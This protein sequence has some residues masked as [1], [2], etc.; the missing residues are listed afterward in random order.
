[1]K[2]NLHHLLTQ[3]IRS[4]SA[5]RAAGRYGSMRGSLTGAL[6]V[7]LIQVTSMQNSWSLSN[8]DM[9]KLYAH[10]LIVDYKEFHKD[11]IWKIEP[12]ENFDTCFTGGRDG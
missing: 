1:M 7:I 8:A 2:I 5:H 12:S 6:C 9:F 4:P 11:S 10:T 3:V